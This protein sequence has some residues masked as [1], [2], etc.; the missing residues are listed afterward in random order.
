MV[1]LIRVFVYGTLKPGEINYKPY[2]EGRVE[3][4]QQAIAF[5]QLYHLS[6]RG[7]PGMT[8]GNTPVHGVVI[9]FTDPNIFEQMDWLETY[10]PD[11]PPAENEYQR[12]KIT[13]FDLNGQSLGQVWVYLMLPE[14]IEALGGTL[15]AHG[16]WGSGA[17]PA[18]FCLPPI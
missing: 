2:C 12:E 8:I 13:V 4:W 7:Y 16:W 6:Q 3:Q 9:S 1:N 10:Q 5:G 15:I 14:R 11:R 18:N 17:P